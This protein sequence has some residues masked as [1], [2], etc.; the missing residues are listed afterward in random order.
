MC[1]KEI[2]TNLTARNTITLEHS[3]DP[4]HIYTYIYMVLFMEQEAGH[5]PPSSVEDNNGRRHT[6]TSPYVLLAW[7]VLRNFLSFYCVG[8]IRLIFYMHLN[9]LKN[10]ANSNRIPI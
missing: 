9:K 4:R 3:Y 10:N 1:K 6:S 8:Y 7:C 2:P 5:S